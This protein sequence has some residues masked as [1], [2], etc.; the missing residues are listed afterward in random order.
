MECVLQAIIGATGIV[1]NSLKISGNGIRKTFSVFCTKWNSCT[2]DIS[3][4]KESAIFRNLK[5]EWCDAPLVQEDKYQ[6]ERKPVTRDNTQ[7][8]SLCFNWAPRHE[9]VVGI[10]D[11]VPRFLDLGTR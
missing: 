5:P 4:D 1:S 8:L 6:G 11:T 7:K 10:G 9:G 3:H 2:R